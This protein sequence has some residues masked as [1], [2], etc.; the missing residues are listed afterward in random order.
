M[1]V[2]KNDLNCLNH[3]IIGVGLGN[4]DGVHIGH[5]KLINVLNEECK[6]RNLRS[7]IY[8]FYKHPENI[9]SN[10]IVTP[11][12]T[13][14]KYKV[15]QLSKY[16]IDYLYLEE[17]SN[18]YAKMNCKEFID[19]ILVQKLNAKLV[20]VGQNFRFGYKASGDTNTLKELTRDYN[21]DVIV[22]DF[23]Y[24]NNEIVSST[25]IRDYI[26]NG[27]IEKANE[28][29]EQEYIIEGR[30]TK[31]SEYIEIIPPSYVVIPKDG[32]YYVEINSNIN[33][34][35]VIR[36]ENGIIYIDNSFNITS[37]CVIK[38]YKRVKDITLYYEIQKKQL[39]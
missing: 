6:K 2:I 36:I 38:F 20:V 3:K 21:I 4:F 23:V 19:K 8:T 16:N 39:V 24:K 25:K 33:V 10:K 12:I 22:V 30:V 13:P 29:L 15:T 35:S 32:L 7:M 37:K 9:M 28:Y 27:Y 5:K 31:N 18:D 11:I 26:S 1:R 34:C 17:F 14:T